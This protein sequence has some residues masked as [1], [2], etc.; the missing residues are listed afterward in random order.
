M[1]FEITP[2]GMICGRSEA[3]SRKY[4]KIIGKSR[5]WY[6]AIQENEADNVYVAPHTSENAPDYKGFR[7]FGG[8]IIPFEL[9]DGTIDNVQGPWHSNSDALFEDT[10]Y[11]IRNKYLTFGVI[12]RAI[13]NNTSNLYSVI[14]KDVI[15]KDEKPIIGSF[16]RIEDLAQEIADK[17]GKIV[18]Y[19]SQGQGGSI[20][21]HK[22][23]L[24]MQNL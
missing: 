20:R 7:G 4:K 6:I 17:E 23:P 21:S 14:M 10:G 2:Q 8:A 3:A 13:E 16:N 12:S 1:D 9:E 24:W 18:Y 15:Y 5:V 11:D 19:Y 22:K